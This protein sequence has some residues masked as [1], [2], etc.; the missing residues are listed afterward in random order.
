MVHSGLL[1]AADAGGS[2]SSF[3]LFARERVLR[4]FEARVR[5]VTITG[6]AGVGKTALARAIA[7][8]PRRCLGICDLGGERSFDGACA[9]IA[10]MLDIA[11]RFD[12]DDDDV[13]R[14][15]GGVLA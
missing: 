11:L 7:C 15:I 14:A 4:L 10:R 12:G 2:P 6:V 9:A 8:P 5:L 1:S 3:L 13:I